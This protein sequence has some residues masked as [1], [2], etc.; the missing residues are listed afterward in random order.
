MAF[1][2]SQ[3]SGKICWEIMLTAAIR[4]DWIETT[5]TMSIEQRVSHF[6]VAQMRCLSN[7]P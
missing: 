4:R 7:A 1:K 3:G 6:T 2:L 5:M